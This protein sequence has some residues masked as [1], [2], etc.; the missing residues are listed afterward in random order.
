MF[1][2]SGSFTHT[3]A[4]PGVYD[5]FGLYEQQG[6]VATIVVGTPTLD[7]QPAFSAS[8]ETLPAAARTQLALHHEAVREMLA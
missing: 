3:P 1:Q 7:A 8:D 5:A 2:G 6:Q 4:E